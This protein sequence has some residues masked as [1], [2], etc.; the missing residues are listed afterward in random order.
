ML[1]KLYQALKNTRLHI[2]TVRVWRK[3]DPPTSRGGAVRFG[4]V[5]F[6]QFVGSGP[7]CASE[8]FHLANH[9]EAKAQKTQGHDI[10]GSHP[11]TSQRRTRREAQRNPN[12]NDCQAKSTRGVAD[13]PGR[14]I[15]FIDFKRLLSKTRY[16][17]QE[18]G[19]SY[20]DSCTYRFLVTNIFFCS[21]GLHAFCFP[22]TAEYI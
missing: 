14:D 22:R 1:R 12:N 13:V 8:F 10:A 5:V 9:K 4:S 21:L 7:L 3:K 6:H 11:S 19:G 20:I 16:F 17:P 2:S 18:G 15:S